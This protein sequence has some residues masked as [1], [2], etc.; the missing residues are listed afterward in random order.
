M[1]AR[2]AW[3]LESLGFAAVHRYAA[4]ETDWAAAG[5][6]IEGTRA[7]VPRVGALAR[8]DVPTCRLDERVGD[9]RA[10]VRA[11]GWDLCVVVNDR[12]VVLGRLRERQLDADPAATAEQVMEVGPTTIR[13]DE[14][15]AEVA[16]HLAE[17]K[18]G[19]VL[20]TTGDGELVGLFRR[21]DG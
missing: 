1:S 8:R 15:A 2:A 4:G 21:D 19:H 12:R 6:P 7:A 20:V 5:F 11:A 18:V 3:R 16:A 14:P 9:V 13:P 10:R 17:R